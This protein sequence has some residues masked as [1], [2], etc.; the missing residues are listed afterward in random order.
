LIAT[1]TATTL[2][3]DSSL[4]GAVFAIARHRVIARLLERDHTIECLGGRRSRFRCHDAQ[5]RFASHSGE[6]PLVHDRIG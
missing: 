3:E 5:F 6:H 1:T 2:D 4:R